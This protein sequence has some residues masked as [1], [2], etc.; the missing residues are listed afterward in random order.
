MSSKNA[1]SFFYGAPQVTRRPAVMGLRGMVSSGHYLASQA[2][3]RMLQSGGNAIDAGVAAGMCLNVLLPHLTSLG[4]VAPIILYLARERRVTT[5]SGLGRWPRSASIDAMKERGNGEIPVGVLR[6]VT[7]AAL[8]A[9]VMALARY[10][11][12][13]FEEVAT[14]ALE[15][16]EGG[17]GV[18]RSLS[19]ALTRSQQRFANWPSTLEVFYPKG[20][21]PRSGQVLVQRDLANT[22]RSLMAA[23]SAAASGDREAGL[24]AVRDTF[25]RGDIAETM[26]S[27][28]Q[29]QG[30]FL[31]RDDLAEFEVREEP[32]VAADY[33]GHRVFSCDSWCQ[34]PAVPQALKLMEGLDLGAMGHNTP[35]YLHHLAEAIKLTFA[36]RERYYG[37]PDF[38]D[39]PL[40]TLL[41]PAYAEARRAS[42]D[43]SRAWPEMY[44]PG[45][46]RRTGAQASQPVAPAVAGGG[47]PQGDTSY[48]CAIDSGGN[49]F[50]ATPSDFIGDVPIVPGL[51]IIV[52]GRGT[53]SWLD[54]RHPASLQPWKRPRL[55]PNPAIALR[56]GELF[57]TFGTPGGD[58]QPQGM[59]Q[60]FLNVVEFGMR[61]QEAVEAPRVGSWSFPNSFWPH[62]YLP[63]RLS[64]EA[65][66]PP[67]VRRALAGLG[68]DIEVWGKLEPR[69]GHV[70]MI[71]RD[72]ESG[73]L[74]GGADPRANTAAIAW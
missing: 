64:V 8:D 25:Y 37:D 62:E 36:D 33:K 11:T 38:V 69:L 63:G 53:Q 46:P 31:T 65:S 18:D 41:S 20:G 10:G 30:G 50:S 6:C 60:A 22:L 43:P 24:R 7:P 13:S 5:I 56:D 73:V 2:G 3:M 1:S 54:P 26:A 23:E 47:S 51:G 58:Q 28:I 35:A 70:C 68:H 32:P 4:G 17:F 39:V 27:F 71:V 29:Q 21:P 48:V 19:G 67:R 72:P 15:F 12:L 61:P 74:H 59:V 66:I 42:I 14:P 9:W 45:D 49:G 52:S 57:M 40:D 55:T 44:P 16:A 34:G